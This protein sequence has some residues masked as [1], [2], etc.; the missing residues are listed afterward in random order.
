MRTNHLEIQKNKITNSVTFKLMVIGI[1]LL[2][3]LIPSSMIKK[4]ILEREKR[5]DET[6]IE[7]TSKWGNAQTLCGPILTIPYVTYID[8]KNGI[9]K[10]RHQANFL[11]DDLII[12]GT[13]IPEVRYRGIYKVIAYTAQ[14]KFA[15]KFNIL[16]FSGLKIKETDILWEETYL[17]I[18]ITDMRGINRNII[19]NWNDSVL[20][21]NPGLKNNHIM[22]SGVTASPKVCSD[23]HHEFNFEI[24]L[25]GSHYLN[26][27]PLGKETNVNLQS[28]WNTP[29]FDGAFLPDE[30]NITDTGFIAHW[31]ILQLNRNYPQKWIDNEFDLD[32][33]EFGIKLLFPVDTYLKAMRSVKYSLLFI[34]LTFLVFFFSEI[35]NKK[36][37][38]FIH[39]MLVGIALIIFYSLLIALSEHIG[40]NLSYLIASL[41]I[42]GL[43]TVFS[44]SIFQKKYVTF[45]ILVVLIVLYVFLFTILQL[46]SY[47]LLLGNI[48]LFIVLALVMYFSK[49]VDWFGVINKNNEN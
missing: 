9:K 11:P 27:I 21:V 4:M 26:F 10:S 35:L 39:Y 6:I 1:L 44:N 38:H 14:L 30:H 28:T 36:R 48:G 32:H 16:D 24:D 19:I 42:V 17:S 3:L 49:K 45:V 34:T 5:R 47:S 20:N 33:S 43:I 25:N 29:S 46:A 18:G 37:I 2:L 8:T 40:F 41:A 31:N 7:V 23:K 22:S 12:S 15:G 13:L